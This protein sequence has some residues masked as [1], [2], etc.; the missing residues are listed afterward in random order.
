MD[1]AQKDGSVHMC[2]TGGDM[3][4]GSTEAVKQVFYDPAQYDCL[5]FDDIFEDTGKPIGFF[6]P[7]YMT[8]N[9]FKDELGNTDRA[10]A[11]SYLEREREK[12]KKGKSKPAFGGKLTSKP[13]RTQVKNISQTR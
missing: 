3:E 1:G 13:E 5:A 9:D 6:F 10:A 8:L 7:A 11:V 2:G 4:G 12:L